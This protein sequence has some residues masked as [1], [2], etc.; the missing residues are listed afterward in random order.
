MNLILL[1]YSGLYR[2]MEYGLRCPVCGAPIEAVKRSANWFLECQECVTVFGGFSGSK[3]GGFPSRQE[4]V[5]AF[6]MACA[7]KIKN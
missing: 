1:N 3:A 4:A 7:S 6:L 5:D 2:Q